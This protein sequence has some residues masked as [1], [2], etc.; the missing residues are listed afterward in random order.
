MSLQQ[1]LGEFYSAEGSLQKNVCHVYCVVTC[2]AKATCD[3]SSTIRVS[4]CDFL[5]GRSECIRHRSRGVNSSSTE[6]NPTRTLS[7]KWGNSA[8]SCRTDQQ[9]TEATMSDN[10]TKQHLERAVY[11]YVRQSTLQQVLHNAESGR[12]QYALKQLY[13]T[14]SSPEFLSQAA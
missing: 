12:R 8:A 5:G 14:H 4:F 13:L 11:I 3:Y 1:L 7:P 6:L 2:V 9:T 10:I